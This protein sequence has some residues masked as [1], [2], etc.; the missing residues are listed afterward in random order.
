MNAFES[1]SNRHR[2]R[3]YVDRVKLVFAL[4]VVLQLA[5]VIGFD[6]CMHNIFPGQFSGV[7]R[8]KFI[9]TQSNSEP[10]GTDVENR[11]YEPERNNSSEGQTMDSGGRLLRL[12]TER[13]QARWFNSLNVP[14]FLPNVSSQGYLV[15]IM[16]IRNA[17]LACFVCIKAMT[18][19]KTWIYSW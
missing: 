19:W 2:V 6:L 18:K 12:V 16:C 13:P 4:S 17:K 15:G 9:S 14:E 8:S 10:L 3:L 11:N 5:C 7:D 1:V